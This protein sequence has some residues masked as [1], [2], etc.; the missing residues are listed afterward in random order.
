MLRSIFTLT[1]LT[2]AA[3]VSAAAGLT[4]SGTGSFTPV[5]VTPESSTGLDAVYVVYDASGVT[6][7]YTASTPSA[8]VVWQRYD[9]RGGGFAE[10]IDVTR[11]GS[12]TTCTLTPDDCGL[13]IRENGRPACFWITNYANHHA[14]LISADVS[15]DSDCASTYLNVVAENAGDIRYYTINGAPRTLSREINVNFNTLTFDETDN[16][17]RQTPGS[18]VFESINQPLRIDAPLCDTSFSIS[19][20]RFLREWNLEEIIETPTAPARAV[21]AHTEAVQTELDE[22]TSNEIKDGSTGLGGSAPVEILFSAAVTDAAVYTEW[23]FSRYSDF[24]ILD[25]RFFQTEVSNVFD[26]TGTT[27]VRFVTA[28]DSGACEYISPSYEISIGESRLQCPNAFS[29]ANQDGVND[30]WKVSY[31]SIV[32]FECHIFNRWGVKITEFTQP[33][34]GWDGRFGG[35][36]VPSGVYY[37]VIK[38]RGSDGKEYNLSGDINVINYSERPG[39]SGDSPT[40]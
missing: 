16:I 38:A 15:A 18:A 12:V 27:Y 1:F 17:Y 8:E 10:T 33:W 6:A 24:S 34:Q 39:T 35:K 11:Q 25:Y 19:A 21:E 29:P 23:Q 14:H 37:Y 31:K 4:F 32:S 7:S 36:F 9:S 3:A 2:V 13:I 26:E 40:E 30:E 28:D 5:T 20:D 22:D